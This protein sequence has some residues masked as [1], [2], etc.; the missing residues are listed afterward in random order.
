[1]SVL[2]FINV[3]RV[4]LAV[5][6]T[7]AVS[8]IPASASPAHWTPDASRITAV[9]VASTQPLGTFNGADYV[10][11]VGTVQGVVGPDEHVVGLDAVPKD[12]AGNYPYSAQF[13]LI[14]AADGEPRS[15]AVVVEAE[16]RGSP[17]VFDAA[18][19]LGLLIGPPS[20]IVYPAGLGNGFLQNAGLS[21]ARVQ[22]QG[23]NAATVVNPTVPATAQGVGEVIMRDFGLL[24]RGFGT[25]TGLPSFDT[26]L[27]VGVSQSAWFVNTFVAE[28][29]NEP[30]SGRGHPKPRRVFDGA[31]AQDGVG[32]WLALNQINAE[33]GFTSQT[34]YVQK[35][36]V[37]ISPRKLLRRPLS[38]P[39]FVDTTAYT[40]YYRV[41]ASLF[42]DHRLL[43][44]N[45]REYNVPNAHASAA[46][47]PPNTAPSRVNCAV[48]AAPVPALNP[49]DGRPYTR[50]LILGLA[51][52]VGVHGLR[53]D[54]P[55][56]PLSNQ[57][58]LTDGPSAPGTDANGV[59]LFNFLPGV[60]LK[61]PVVNSD[62]Q[63]SG[64]LARYPDL[65]L[66]LG[67]PS[68]VA[69]PPV[70]TNSIL[71]ICGNFGGWRPFSSSELAARYGSVS[72]YVTAYDELLD[73]LVER[74][75]VLEADRAG[76]LAFVT[77]LYNAAP[78]T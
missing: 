26:A 46:S 70:G 29:F 16:N 43:P 33:E 11:L 9:T 30:P 38:D 22:W 72:A 12:A 60:D 32:N 65:S 49:L 77:T 24:L 25:A 31:Y 36:G 8:G 18:Q 23:P 42:N 2:R 13:E 59:P 52:R 40:D 53:V 50:A 34:P 37:P 61:V 51:R 73:P 55:H 48:G 21:W 54:A 45:L 67:V 63:P 5:A 1:M 6:L 14:T 20:T 66:P 58:D 44:A 69:I 78:T 57:F 62:G 41:R 15:D 35:D 3:L 75:R 71:D 28:G 74:G 7:V 68:P 47:L 19:N 17:L 4:F 10:R 27:L 56:L 64:G 39:F 76:I